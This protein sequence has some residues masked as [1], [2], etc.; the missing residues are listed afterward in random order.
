MIRSR[1][2]LQS[3]QNIRNSYYSA[4]K[5]RFF[6]SPP[7]PTSIAHGGRTVR[8]IYAIC[9]ITLTAEVAILY[10]TARMSVDEEFT[11]KVDKA[12]PILSPQLHKFKDVIPTQL[13]QL[14]KSTLSPESTSKSTI[15]QT[16]TST[17]PQADT[18]EGTRSNLTI[19]PIETVEEPVAEVIIHDNSSVV[20]DSSASANPVVTP[21]DHNDSGPASWASPKLAKSETYNSSEHDIAGT[22]KHSHYADAR[23]NIEFLENE[24]EIGDNSTTL[25]E[26]S[27]HAWLALV[28]VDSIL[29]NNDNPREYVVL[30]NPFDEPTTEEQIMRRY[31]GC[32]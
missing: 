10:V 16:S 30:Q 12:V 32:M 4:S 9:G 26:P 29:K 25:S 11:K 23:I 7:G 21:H 2:T 3:F 20:E 5:K 13:K 6:S 28:D 31:R 17:I 18:E 8:L 19:S 1:K 24:S 27:T 15:T 22:F 14:V